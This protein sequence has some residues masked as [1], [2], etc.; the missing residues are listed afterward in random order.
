[1]ADN[2]SHQQSID[3]SSWDLL[4]ICLDES[5]DVTGSVRLAIFGRYLVG[6]IIKEELINLSSL[7]TTT[8]G[9]NI[10]NAVVKERAERKLDLSKIVSVST[11]AC[12]QYDQKR[13]WLYQFIYTAYWAFDF[14]LSLHYTS[15]S[16]TCKNCF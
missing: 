6:N 15:A 14:E 2:V 7:E 13:E 12:L 3:I 8:R 16:V 5:T 11:E 10:C 4:S 1:M 9:I